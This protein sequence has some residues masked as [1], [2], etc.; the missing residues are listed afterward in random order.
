MWK[1]EVWI[2]VLWFYRYK[3]LKWDV[4]SKYKLFIKIIGWKFLMFIMKGFRMKVMER[5][6]LCGGFFF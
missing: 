1:L 4:R 5:G 3:I 6:N 2:E